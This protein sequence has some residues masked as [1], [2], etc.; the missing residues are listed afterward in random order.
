MN[1]Y[2]KLARKY[3][4][5]GVVDIA[6]GTGAV[7]LYLA[8]HGIDVDGTDISE[9]KNIREQLADGGILTLNTCDP[10]PIIQAEQM[11]SSTEEYKFIVE[12][13]NVNGYRE[14]IYNALTYNPVLQQMHGNW[15][16]ETYNENGEIIGERIRPILMRHTYR[17]EMKWLAELCGFE[18]F[19]IY[20]DFKGNRANDTP[21]YCIW[22]LRKKG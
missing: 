22:L 8:E 6:C 20:S 4:S 3:G 12:Y 18:V 9:E 14:K 2:V 19:E 1:L 7:L 5:G 16:F 10:L 15:K 11:K 13:V 17:Q 21:G